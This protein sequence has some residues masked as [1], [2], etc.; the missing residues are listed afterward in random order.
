MKDLNLFLLIL[1]QLFIALP[2]PVRQQLVGT[3]RRTVLQPVFG[4]V[5]TLSKVF[6]FIRL[7][8]LLKD[9]LQHRNIEVYDGSQ[10]NQ[11]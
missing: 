1:G 5:Q 2:V 4:K 11:Q 10:L 7:V 9:G 8:D 3:F 6:I